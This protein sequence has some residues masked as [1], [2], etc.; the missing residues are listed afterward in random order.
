MAFE[1]VALE[2]VVALEVV[3]FEVAHLGV[4]EVM[5][6]QVG[7]HLEERALL[8]YHLDPQADLILIEGIDHTVAII[9][10]CGGTIDLGITVGGIIQ[11]GQGIIIDLGII[12]QYM[13]VG[14]LR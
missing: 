6:D 11:C 4:E 9:D 3:G 2:A 8:E 10:Q 12:L 13:L 14:V 7:D 1:V 5:E